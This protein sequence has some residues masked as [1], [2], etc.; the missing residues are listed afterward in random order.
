MNE[1]A[2]E[3]FLKCGGNRYY[4]SLNGEEHEY[5]SYQ[6]SKEKEDAWR[7]EYLECFSEKKHK[8]KEALKAYSTATEFLKSDR[9]D[10]DWEDYLYYPLRS[11]WLDDVTVL[12]MLP[13][14]FRLAERWNKKI[15]LSKENVKDY[16]N[17]LD[18]FVQKV[19]ERAE[20]G[21]LTR[22]EDYTW[23]EFSDPVYLASY[24]ADIQERWKKL[25]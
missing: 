5:D 22:D 17:V 25:L 23:Q 14:S 18:T 16:L 4:M 6:I 15:K 3:L 13:V 2:K 10:E 20:D 9:S 19:Q 24:T 12:F 7:R 8:G 1:R 11:E 21:T